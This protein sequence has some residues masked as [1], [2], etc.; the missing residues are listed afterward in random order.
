[1]QDIIRIIKILYSTIKS[2]SKFNQSSFD[3]IVNDCVISLQEG[4][5]DICNENCLRLKAENFVSWYL[6]HHRFDENVR[7]W[8]A[9]IFNRASLEEGSS[10]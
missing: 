7:D 8:I 4:G 1:M 3:E 6:N 5:Y 10:I 9:S 2:K